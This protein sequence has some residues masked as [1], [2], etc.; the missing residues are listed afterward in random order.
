MTKPTKSFTALADHKLPDSFDSAIE[1]CH[2]ASILAVDDPNSKP[3]KEAWCLEK[4]LASSVESYLCDQE[5]NL[6][7]LGSGN[8][9]KAEKIIATIK[10][11]GALPV[12]Y[13]PIDL[14]PYSCVYAILTIL[15]ADGPILSSELEAFGGGRPSAFTESILRARPLPYEAI[16]R[17]I[18]SGNPVAS[19]IARE[20]IIVPTR[21]LSVDF[22]GNTD[23]VMRTV[24]AQKF[25]R[26][27]TNIFCLLGQTFGN[28][29][30]LERSDFLQALW[31][32]MN[33]GD[34]LLIDGGVKPEAAEGVR[35][36]DLN[37]CISR[38]VGFYRHGEQFMRPDADSED[39]TY[40]VVYNAELG[41]IQYWFLRCDGS[42][43]DFGFSNMWDITAF[44]DE[45]SAA[46]FEVVNYTS[47]LDESA[48]NAGP[49]AVAVL[50]RKGEQ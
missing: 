36:E 50:A 10:R 17:D 38:L 7:D 47:S 20:K 45:I 13:F 30:E 35:E 28:Y 48:F 2:L 22:M 1:Y 46:G 15:C 19:M 32:Q 21:G 42:R 29:D 26:S 31:Q 24:T 16:L 5:I 37:T 44:V 14:S 41:R 6:V 43:Q 23:E 9:E 49:E 39:S 12:R 34:L 11:Y 8:G 3:G 27:G 25:Y 33:P 4:L 40:C 18:F